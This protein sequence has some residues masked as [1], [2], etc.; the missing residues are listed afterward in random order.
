MPPTA[1]PCLP[2]GDLDDALDYYTT[3]LGF[4]AIA[5]QRQPGALPGALLRGHGVSMR[6]VEAGGEEWRDRPRHHSFDAVFL[7]DRPRSLRLRLD[8]SGARFMHPD[9]LGPGWDGFFGVADKYG[10][11]LGFG[12]APGPAAA[13]KRAVGDPL[14]DLRRR[15]HE[16]RR[17][18]EERGHLEEF[19]AFYEGLADRRGIFYLFFSGRLLQWVAKCL[20]YVPDDV[21]LVLLGSD[22]PPDELEWVRTSTNRPFHHVRLRLDDQVAWEFLFAVNRHDFGW[23]DS[24]CLVLDPAL[25]AELSTMDGRSALN[26]TW[27]WDGGYG[28]PL[29]NTFLLYVNASVIRALREKGVP[30]SPY[31]YDYD[32]Q[33][34]RIP[35]RRAYSRRPTRAQLARLRGV[36]PADAQ[37]RPRTPHGMLYFDTMVMYQLVARSLGHPIHQVRALEGFGHLRGR[38]V[39]DESSDELLHIGGV[40]KADVLTGLTGFFHDSDVRVLY[41]VAELVILT[42]HAAR[43]PAYYQRRLEEVT[44]T[45][46][47]HGL[48]PQAACRLIEDHLTQVRGMSRRSVEAIVA[49]ARLT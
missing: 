23:I 9:D 6:L 14:D 34:L 44:A 19:R 17:A 40:S 1:I 33:N 25:F 5:G 10:N 30:A 38:D 41:L 16:R 8:D 32:W 4:E 39:Q 24:D 46:A 45:L 13:V 2:V 42:E 35:G 20:S 22:L 27:S 18:A 29:A 37:G 43:L 7:V 15:N 21:N 36:V 48:S 31:S 12:P 26:C 47:G 11:T 49:G 28:F 3:V